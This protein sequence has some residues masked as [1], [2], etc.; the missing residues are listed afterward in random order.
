MIKPKL[1][2]RP[3]VSPI[4]ALSRAAPPTIAP[5][6]PTKLLSGAHSFRNQNP[7]GAV[8]AEQILLD[9]FAD[10]GRR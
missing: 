6:S 3:R 9:Q 8:N 2:T 4:I 1:A 7:P 10:G 5:V